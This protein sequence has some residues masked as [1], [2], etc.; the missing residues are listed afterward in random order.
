MNLLG[1][2][3]RSRVGAEPVEREAGDASRPRRRS[4]FT[5][6][7]T[8]ACRRRTAC[9]SILALRRAGVPAEMHIYRTGRHGLGLAAEHTRHLHLARPAQGLDARCKGC[10]A[11]SMTA[12]SAAWPPACGDASHSAL[13]RQNAL[14]VGEILR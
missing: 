11:A 10:W 12:D 1:A 5:P 9:S 8:R 3:R 7:K 14:Q 4:S 2:E 13:S 6:T